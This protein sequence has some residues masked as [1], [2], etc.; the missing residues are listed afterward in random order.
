V[1]KLA[2]LGRSF[3]A[4]GRSTERGEFVGILTGSRHSDGSKIVVVHVTHLVS[5]E[6]E[7]VC[8]ESILITKD[9]VVGRTN[10]SLTG[11]ARDQ[12]K[13]VPVI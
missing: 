1:K 5:D 11:S 9:V 7:L 3:F 13:V 4:V 8:I 10:G 2:Q 12:V 6:L